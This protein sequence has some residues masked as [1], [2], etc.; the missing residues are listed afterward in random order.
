MHHGIMRAPPGGLTTRDGSLSYVRGAVVSPLC[1]SVALFAA[2]LGGGL[3][4]LLGAVTAFAFV[5]VLAACSTRYRL[6]RQHLDRQAQA[7][8]RCRREAARTKQLRPAGPVRLQ[9]YIELRQLVEDIERS[10]AREAARFELQDLLEHFISLAVSQQRCL[11]ALRLVGSHDLSQ[12]T[13]ITESARSNIRREIRARR[14]R[15]RDACLARIDHLGDEIEAVDELVRLVAQ[16]VACP[17]LDLDADR[18]IN[19]RLWELDE[20]DAAI[21]QLSA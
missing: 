14:M 1:I 21:G 15:H 10:D 11:D 5:T 8:E 16:R 20:V 12:A 2:C 3:V 13:P 18:E 19:R 6:V 17:P 7:R 9:Q 4:G